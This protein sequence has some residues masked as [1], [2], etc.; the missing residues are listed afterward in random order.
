M[1]IFCMEVFL[2]QNIFMTNSKL[3]DFNKPEENLFPEAQLDVPFMIA[4]YRLK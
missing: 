4:I 1:I 2:L 3:E